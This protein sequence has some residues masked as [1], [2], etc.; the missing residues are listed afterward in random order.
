MA[1]K[2]FRGGMGK[3]VWGLFGDGDE[4]EVDGNGRVES[5]VVDKHEDVDVDIDDS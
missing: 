1:R 5:A 2:D 4:A 3:G